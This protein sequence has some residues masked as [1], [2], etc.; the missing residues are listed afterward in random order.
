[1]VPGSFN[2]RGMGGLAVSGGMIAAGR[3][4]RSDLLHRADVEDARAVLISL[5]IS[6]VIDLRTGGERADDGAFPDD[7]PIEVIHVPVLADVWSWDD[8]RAE[9][10][11][12][13]LR[14]RTIE[15][16][17][18]RGEQMITVLRSIAESG[19]P[20]VFHCTAG[21]DRTGAVAAALLGVLGAAPEVIMEDYARSA[22]AMPAMVEW[23]RSQMAEHHVIGTGDAKD[24]EAIL[25]RAALPAT[26][27]G[28]VDHIGE[29]YGSFRGW[30]AV[31]GFDDG[32]V[33]VLARRLVAAPE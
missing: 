26:M 24:H 21:K 18:G 10:G 25:A 9:A 30:A 11:D 6:R 8:E 14:D 12:H 20:V 31:N 13:F 16:F 15:M 32:D 2:F 23:Y 29:R 1:M 5:G 4:F 28:L 22:L 33:A 19:G 27:A 17:D 7:A 3:V